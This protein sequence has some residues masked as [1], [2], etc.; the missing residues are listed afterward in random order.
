MSDAAIGLTVMSS[1]K[2]DLTRRAIRNSSRR[3]TT[4]TG[5]TPT[6]ISC[7]RQERIRWPAIIRGHQHAA[8]QP[9]RWRQGDR[10]LKGWKHVGVRGPIEID[11][12][13]RDI[14]QNENALGSDQEAG[15][16]AGRESAGDLQA[17]KDECKVLKVGRCGPSSCPPEFEAFHRSLQQPPYRVSSGAAPAGLSSYGTGRAQHHRQ[18]S[19]RRSGLGHVSVHHF[20]RPFG[21]DGADGS[22]QLGAW[23]VRHGGRLFGS[24]RRR[25]SWSV[26]F[27]A[28]RSSLLF[29]LSPPSVF[30]SSE[31]LYCATLRRQRTRS[32][33]C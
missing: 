6:P 28:A 24:S 31:L 16:E 3:G 5:R 21:H 25:M 9:G 10:A 18:Y 19:V 17:V 29:W 14:V 4:L 23:R 32:G 20:C 30:C 27:L 11:P 1:Y 7:R 22:R 12:E 8:R 15:R 13:T 2:D 33:A 26:P